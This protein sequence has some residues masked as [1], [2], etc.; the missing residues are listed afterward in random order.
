[1][2]NKRFVTSALIGLT[3]NTAA[4]PLFLFL[5]SECVRFVCGTLLTGTVLSHGLYYLLA[6]HHSRLFMPGHNEQ[7]D[8]V[9]INT[10][11]PFLLSGIYALMTTWPYSTF[12][13]LVLWASS[14]LFAESYQALTFGQLFPLI[15]QGGM[16]VIG[17][18]LMT[19]IQQREKYVQQTK[20]EVGCSDLGHY[21]RHADFI[22]AMETL[23]SAKTALH[24]VFA[25]LVV[26][27]WTMRFFS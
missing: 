5:G 22:E 17:H 21:E 13:G 18:G 19:G 9:M 4:L 26:Y 15:L 25:G 10:N 6:R 16:F 7:P 23:S 14:N 1:M 12:M 3:V 2:I 20:M 24:A 8:A 11:S 27:V